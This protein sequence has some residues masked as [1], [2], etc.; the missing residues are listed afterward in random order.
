MDGRRITF[1]VFSLDLINECLW[2]G[3]EPIKLRPKAFAVINYLVGRPGQLVTKQELLDT[4]WPETFVGD[5]VLKVAIRELRD[6]LDDDP[7]SPRFIETAHRR[8]YRFIGQVTPPPQA[9]ETHPGIPSDSAVSVSLLRAT[10]SLMRVVGREEALSQMKVWLERVL[11]GKR[12]I[13]FISGEAG[14][15][16]TAIVDLFVHSISVDRSTRIATGQCLEQYGTSEPFLPLLDA[17]GRLCR[18]RAEV[19]DVLRV[20]A[21]MWL[22]QMPSLV[23]ACDREKLGHGI[24]GATRERMLREMGDA[25]EVLTERAPLVL[26]LEDL[27]WSDYSTLDLVSY[28]ARQRQPAKLMLIG[29]Y[30]P[31]DLI[32]SR[33]PLKAVKQELLAKSECEELPLSYL[34]SVDVEKYL[35]ARFPANAFPPKL[36]QLI[37]GRTEGNPLYM[38]NTVDYLVSD[39]SIDNSEQGW[40]LVAEIEKLEL[41]VPDT[42]KQMIEKQIEYFEPEQQRI[43][44]AASVA[45]SEFSTL[46]VA[47][48]LRDDPALVEARLDELAHDGHFIHDC[49][50]QILPSGEAVSR[51][52]FRHALYQNVLYERLA[53]AKRMQ[54]HRDIGEREEEIY[55]ERSFEIATELAMHFELGA[56]YEQ[57]TKYLRRAAENAIRRF[58]YREAVVLARRG[59]ELFNQLPDRA[60]RASQELC[61]QLTLGVPLIATEG[62]ASPEVG[63]VYLRA[64][65]LCRQVG[66]TP[67]LAEVLWG[68]GTFHT[69][70]AELAK[71]RVLGEEFLEL[72]ERLAYPGFALRGHWA[73]E[74]ALMHLGEFTLSLEHYDKALSL[75]DPQR[76]VD[77]AFLYAQNP[78]VAMRCFAACSLWFLGEPDR[79]LDRMQEALT[80]ARELSE[81]HGLAHALF[82]ASILHQL[83]REVLPA[84]KHADEAI[85]VS[86]EHGLA[87]YQAMA[88]IVRCWTV[89][90]QQRREVPLEQMRQAIGMLRSTGTELMQ[91]HFMAL[92]AEVLKKQRRTAE[93]IQVL[94]EALALVDRTAEAYYLAEMHRLKGELLLDQATSRDMSGSRVRGKLELDVEPSAA[95]RAEACFHQSITIAQQ[96]KAKSWELRTLMSLVRL[97]QNQGR[98]QEAKHALE[99]IYGSFTQGHDTPD[100]IDARRLVETHGVSSGA[101]NS[102]SWPSGS[103]K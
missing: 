72:A 46:T 88:T 62:Y 81:P 2:R 14:I 16:K 68:L 55:G 70:R 9:L 15:G 80:I 75:Y 93:G 39:G 17:M 57:A 98:E 103:E 13:V 10:D 28:L 23:S 78:G 27:H 77:D 97:L 41:R 67:D 83:R 36:A 11:V 51:Y 59:L 58:A 53:V 38:V 95:A 61:L 56:R 3:S 35:A 85:V 32:V 94:E 73:I 99:R 65:G 44:E 37:Y 50:I 69:L 8:G 42:I 24:F 92:M 34:S 89:A 6:A 29:T 33:H 47:A 54:M 12:Q 74:I 19:V 7:K 30:R 43:L 87:M 22:M 48:G 45:G 91:P 60:E 63:D 20:H 31:V 90:E 21:P 5:A 18:E 40:E 100:L 96:Q 4:V 86:E 82:F 71:A 26:V 102:K 52:S 1:D 79:A 66:D 25:L 84:Q 64:R 101:Q 49:G 76:H